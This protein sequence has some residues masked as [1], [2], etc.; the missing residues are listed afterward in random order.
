MDE[1]KARDQ[2]IRDAIERLKRKAEPPAVEPVSDIG[3]K[4]EILEAICRSD[5]DLHIANDIAAD[6]MRLDELARASGAFDG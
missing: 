5:Q 6:L 2:R 3:L 1:N 4:L